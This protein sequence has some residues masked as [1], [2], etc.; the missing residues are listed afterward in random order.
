M[1]RVSDTVTCG[2]APKDCSSR[3]TIADGWPTCCGTGPPDRCGP[4]TIDVGTN[5]EQLLRDPLYIGLSRPRL[6]QAQYDELLDEFMQGVADVFPGALVQ[7]EDFATG[8][9]FRLLR[10]YQHRTCCFND[11][12]QG[13]AAMCVAGIHASV[14]LLPV[15]TAQVYQGMAGLL[16]V[17]DPEEDSLGLPSGAGELLC[18]LQDRRFD[19]ANQLVYAGG[20]AGTMG[21]A[22]GRGRGRG[23]GMAG[24]AQMRK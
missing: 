18:V 14:R 15:P 8:N 12:I 9:A 3:R 17:S 24:M 6:P 10:K 11:D 16:L 23:M 19:T 20:A 2:S 22:M 21:E 13:T 1:W 4:I 5:N 7:F